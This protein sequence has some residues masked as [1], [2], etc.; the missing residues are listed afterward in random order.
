M[1]NQTCELKAKVLEKLEQL[2]AQAVHLYSINVTPEV[3]FDLRGQAAGQANYRANRLRFNYELL[4]NYKDEF[5]D[6]T[7][8]HEFAPS[9]LTGYLGTV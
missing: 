5:V 4:K 1:P 8:P 3:L 7:V 6:Q 2:Q 9:S